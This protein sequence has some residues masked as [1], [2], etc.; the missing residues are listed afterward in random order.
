MP[1][2]CESDGTRLARLKLAK[3]R[4]GYAKDVEGRLEAAKA[5]L[6]RFA[7]LAR[8]HGLQP[9][10]ATDQTK[11]TVNAGPNGNLSMRVLFQSGEFWVEGA[12]EAIK[13]L[14]YDP[15]GRCFSGSGHAPG[16]TLIE[17]I[18][19]LADIVV[20]ELNARLGLPS[21]S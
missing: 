6:S 5:L 8:E 16:R 3:F 1:T 19:A 18:D 2:E 21:R 15:I 20:G 4:E 12:S 11:I 14:E 9:H 13:A 17:G 10:L 7:E